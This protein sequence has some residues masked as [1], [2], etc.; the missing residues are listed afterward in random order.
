MERKILFRGKKSNGKWIYGSL[1]VSENI[2]PAIYYEEG[3]GLVRQFDWCYVNSDSI[4]QY[5]GLKD[6]NE[7]EIYEGDIIEYYELGTYCINPDCDIHLLGYGSSL[8]KK[9]GVVQFE[10]GIFGVNDESDYPLTPLS[11]CGIYEDMLNDMKEDTYLKT[12]GFNIDNSIIGIKVIANI[13][14]NPEL[15]E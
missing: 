13:H 10:N 15:M 3:K 2:K 11:D 6:K 14:D 5:T 1:V 7:K 4:G 12:N 9:L 8:D